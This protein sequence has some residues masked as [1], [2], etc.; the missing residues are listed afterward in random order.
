MKEGS[1]DKASYE[2]RQDEI[3]L[4]KNK[5]IEML[6]RKQEE[7]R[8]TQEKLEQ[9]ADLA[10]DQS[11]QE[12][13]RIRQR[14]YDGLLPA[15]FEGECVEI[16]HAFKRFQIAY[17]DELNDLRRQSRDFDRQGEEAYAEYRRQLTRLQE[18]YMTKPDD[19]DEENQRINIE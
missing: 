6:E 13:E 3:I 18:E 10:F 12:I 8:K 1:M 17:E 2:R 19:G 7:N 11:R 5:R 14:I 9:A 4:R 15:R 16:D